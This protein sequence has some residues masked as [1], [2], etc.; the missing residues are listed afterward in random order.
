MKVTIELPD[1][2]AAW[3]QSNDFPSGMKIEDR[4]L[5]ALNDAKRMDEAYEEEVRKA[6]GPIYGE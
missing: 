5:S 2:L 6:G 1:W 4:I 3:L